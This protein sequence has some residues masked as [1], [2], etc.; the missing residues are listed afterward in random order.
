MLV[1]S[2]TLILNILL[3]SQSHS[4]SV[5]IMSKIMLF[6]QRSSGDHYLG[7]H[8]WKD[9]N[10]QYQV[11]YFSGSRSFFSLFKGWQHQHYCT[12]GVWQIQIS[13]QQDQENLQTVF[14]AKKMS[15]TKWKTQILKMNDV[16][17]FRF[18]IPGTHWIGITER[19]QHYYK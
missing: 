15:L 6:S 11:G 4:Q 2:I 9:T 8:G 17:W 13:T 3:H 19:G 10:R 1:V 7:Y 12:T 5:N 18:F 14:S 16:L